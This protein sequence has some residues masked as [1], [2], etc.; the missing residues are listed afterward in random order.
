MRSF[1][2]FRNMLVILTVVM[3][4]ACSSVGQYMTGVSN[5]NPDAVKSADSNQ[6]CDN[7]CHNGWCSS[8]CEGDSSSGN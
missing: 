7:W 2:L 5:K 4:S 3:L 6:K 1:S 8:H